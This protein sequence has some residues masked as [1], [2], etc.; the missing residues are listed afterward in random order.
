MSE[1]QDST[2]SPP[3]RL[4]ALWRRTKDHRIAQWMVGYVA[5]AYGVQHAVTLTSEAFKW[6]DAVIRISMLLL[7]LGL[8]L[9]MVFAWYHG[10]RT[11]RRISA[12]EMTLASLLLVL[13]SLVFYAVVR[14]SPDLRAAATP[15]VQE[16]S[17]I[18]ARQA[19]ASP[20]TAISLAVMPFENLSPDP[21][22]GYFADGTTEEITTALTKIPDLRVVARESAFSFKGKA[23]DVRAIGKALNATHLIEGTIRKAGD[24]LRISAQLVRADTGVTLWAN[25]YDRQLTDVFAVQEDIARSIATS[26]HMTLGLKPGENLVNERTKNAANYDDYLR[27]KELVRQRGVANQ[28]NAAAVLERVVARDPDFAPGWAQLA[29]AYALTP[30]GDRALERPAVE[31]LL[32][33]GEAA[34]RR[35]ICSIQRIPTGI[36]RWA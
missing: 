10:E 2:E 1:Q 26:L 7:A 36:A 31:A 11:T 34:T 3:D 29:L 8:P 33:K 5:L 18:A 35:A 27:A 22:Q 23:Q 20:S 12:G 15:A 17:V 19:A 25:S 4:T 16:A 6:P 24:Q 9:A 21:S 30:N 32:A 13:I 14:P 28:R